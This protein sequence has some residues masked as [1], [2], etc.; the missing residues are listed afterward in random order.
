MTNIYIYIL[1]LPRSDWKGSAKIKE[2]SSVLFI[3]NLTALNFRYRNTSQ[4]HEDILLENF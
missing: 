3:L 1:F 2:I 4:S